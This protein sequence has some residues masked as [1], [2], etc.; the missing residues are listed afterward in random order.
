MV[1]KSYC[2]EPCSSGNATG[3]FQCEGEKAFKA[4]E[5]MVLHN[6]AFYVS[7]LFGVGHP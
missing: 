7:G 6:R 4:N 1:C 3:T 2:A 5:L